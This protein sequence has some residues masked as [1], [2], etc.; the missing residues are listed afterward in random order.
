MSKRVTVRAKQLEQEDPLVLNIAEAGNL[1]VEYLSML[2]SLE[3][4]IE[5]KNL[6]RDCELRQL[7]GC[8]NEMS[9]V[10]LSNKE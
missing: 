5:S 7:S 2:N 6:P 3:N 4:K 1:D 9:L 8:R 10:E